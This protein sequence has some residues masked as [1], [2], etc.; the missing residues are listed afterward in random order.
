MDAKIEFSRGET[1]STI[2]RQLVH[3][4]QQIRGKRVFDPV[5]RNFTVTRYR[6]ESFFNSLPSIVGVQHKRD[7]VAKD[8]PRQSHPLLV[9]RER[10][11][12]TL[13]LYAAEACIDV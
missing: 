7:L 4:V 2:H 9:F 3:F 1:K 12:G 6:R 5:G 11:K 10:P 13:Y 8:L